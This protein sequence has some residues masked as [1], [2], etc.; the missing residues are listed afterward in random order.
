MN[1]LVRGTNWI[2]DAVMTVP[3][4][5]ALRSIFP[6]AQIA[7]HTRPWAEGIFAGAGLFDEIITFDPSGSKLMS[8]LRQ[9]KSLRPKK[10]DLAILFPNSFES[11]LVTKLAGIKHRFGYATDGRKMLLTDSVAVP[12]WKNSRH[13]VFYYLELI[14][15]VET[16][17]FG[18]EHVR[19]VEIEPTMNV[20]GEN[21]AIGRGLLLRS[22]LDLS[23]KTVAL[24][25]GSTN[26]LA[27]RWSAE[28]YSKLND[29]LRGELG[30]NVVLLGARDEVD[31]SQEVINGSQLKPVDLTGKTDL[32]EAAAVLSEIDLLVSNDMGLAH[33]AP[34]VGTET[35]V[36]F[37]P[38][39]PI[40]TRPLSGNA[41]VVRAEGVECS[42]CMLR[43]CPIDHRCMT[44]VTVDEI[45]QKAVAKLK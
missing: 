4:V 22:G 18:T 23:K 20:S 14:A 19:K 44:R 16:S 10:F 32:S 8:I 39:N 38:T 30:V 6:G 45:F 11:A 43:E 36:I 31:V 7:L 25:P 40:T 35:I 37:G 33:L 28:N 42:P 2:G 27:K 34:A 26:S 3:A 5:R 21:R 13:E 24:A 17:F 1:I 9:S 29:K 12:E 15:A 41:E